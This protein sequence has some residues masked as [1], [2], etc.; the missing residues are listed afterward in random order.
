M[1]GVFLIVIDPGIFGDADHYRAMVSEMLAA[2]KRMPPAE[3]GADVLVPGEPE[4]CTRERRSRE[5]ILLPEAT[6]TDLRAV[7][8]R[9]G[10]P[11][12]EVKA[13]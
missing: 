9:F 5:G 2:A 1:A 6:W 7:G 3:T 4:A 11:V 8:A 10:V 13:T 12:P